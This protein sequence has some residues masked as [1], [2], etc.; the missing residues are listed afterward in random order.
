MNEILVDE[1]QVAS[2]T[3]SQADRG[4][5]GDL[6]L[7]IDVCLS[8]AEHRLHDVIGLAVGDALPVGAVGDDAAILRVQGRPYAKG[9][10][11]VVDGRFAFKVSH[12]IESD[13]G[14]HA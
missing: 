12:V 7:A 13:A 8:E 5:L 14:R 2:N 10:L 1:G 9:E 6:E 3:R 11:V 4:F